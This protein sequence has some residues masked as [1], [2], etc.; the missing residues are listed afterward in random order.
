MNIHKKTLNN[1]SCLTVVELKD[2]PS[3]TFATIVKS[4]PFFDPKDRPGLSHFLEHL[5]VKGTK[6]YPDINLITNI[7]ETNGVTTG[8]FTYQETNL[9]WAKAE[10]QKL[11]LIVEILTEQLQN[12]L[13]KK[14]DIALEKNIVIEELNI[15][16]DNPSSLIWELW[17]ENVWQGTPLGRNYI[18]DTDSINGF[19]REAVV[20]FF[21]NN[22][23]VDDT[24]FVITGDTSISEAANLLN[25]NL[26]NYANNKKRKVKTMVFKRKNPINIHT[27]NNVSITAAYGFLTTGAVNG[28]S[29]VLELIETLLGSGWGS[30]LRRNVFQAGL[31]YSIE[32]Y[33][34]HLSDTGYLMSLFTCEKENLNKIIKLINGQLKVIIGG[35]FTSSDIERAKG[36]L[37]SSILFNNEKSDDIACWFAYQEISGHGQV[38]SPQEKCQLVQKIS[39]KEIID[40]A[41]RYFTDKNWYLSA[42]G[43]IKSSEIVNDSLLTTKG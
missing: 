31:T 3:V 11:S 28:D 37:I 22:Y 38:L 12:S 13:F 10:N 4:G 36:Y 18:G 35:E 39:N 27:Q 43:P 20:T 26:T 41:K 5:M 25:Q 30:L 32:T 29:I 24:N 15:L 14:E 33:G 2:S 19:T 6:K 23:L 42:I 8:A 34:R 40:V 17:A 7:L 9:Y 21:N 1:G 16:K